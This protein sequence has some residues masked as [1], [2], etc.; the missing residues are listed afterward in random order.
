[1]QAIIAEL[2][3]DLGR[4]FYMFTSTLTVLLHNDHGLRALIIGAP[5]Y[6]KYMP[7]R[8]SEIEMVARDIFGY[9]YFNSYLSSL[10]VH[11]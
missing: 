1:M 9:M 10:V 4:S 11:S 2:L 7:F 3:L 8:G 5:L 6:C